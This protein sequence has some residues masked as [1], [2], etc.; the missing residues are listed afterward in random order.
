MDVRLT[1]CHSPVRT[2]SITTSRLGQRPGIDGLQSVSSPPPF[3]WLSYLVQQTTFWVVPAGIH[4]VVRAI[5]VLY[6][7]VFSTFLSFL[8][9]SP[10]FTKLIYSFYSAVNFFLLSIQI[11]NKL[12]IKL[13]TFFKFRLS[14]LI[15]DLNGMSAFRKYSLFMGGG[16]GVTIKLQCIEYYTIKIFYLLIMGP[17]RY[18]DI[19]ESTM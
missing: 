1:R 18:I 5:F 17:E 9:F 2:E 14:Q 7:H 10:E 13:I 19:S 6:I 4:L 11:W 15:L 12:N 16:G 3:F 8:I